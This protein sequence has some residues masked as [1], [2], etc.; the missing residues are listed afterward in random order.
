[1]M[2]G[3]GLAV[4]SAASAI[5]AALVVGCAGPNGTSVELERTGEAERQRTVEIDAAT[6]VRL[7]R[8]ADSSIETA[9]A[10]FGPAEGL[11]LDE[12]G[13]RLYRTRGCIDCHGPGGDP[14][15][16]SLIGA[17]GTLREVEGRGPVLMD[18]DYI[19]V[20]LMRPDSLIAKGYPAGEM[21]SYEGTLYPRE[22][23]ALAVYLQGA[24]EEP[25]MPEGGSTIIEVLSGEPVDR[26]R[27]PLIP[28]G[29][30]ATEE[31]SG[32]P[33][34]AGAPAEPA[35]ESVRED[36][37]PEWWFEGVRREDGRLWV[38]VEALGPTFSEARSAA[39]ERGRG[40]IADRMNLD[41]SAS[42]QDLRVR[43]IFVTPLPNRGT[44]TRYAAYA[45]MSAQMGR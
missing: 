43:Y 34:G 3:R 38:C 28:R 2:V 27:S 4:C 13:A 26:V 42:P 45:M 37:R 17:F 29:V 10:A 12:L 19:N 40:Q 44:G 15:G 25:R 5:G 31:P 1:M 22:V 32:Q 23:L 8:L 33:D 9:R 7:R 20:A 24:S 30:E 11:P 18:L 21:P 35:G 6:A 39:I 14:I 41:P 16:P 36:G